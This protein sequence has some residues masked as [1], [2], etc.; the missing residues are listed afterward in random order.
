MIYCLTGELLMLDAVSMTAVIDCGG[1]GYKTTITTSTLSYLNSAPRDKVRIYTYM[2]VREDSV[3]LY[4]FATSEELS[5]FK[6]LITVSGVGPKAAIS[7]LSTLGPEALA[8]TIAAEDAK[9]IAK[10]PGVGAKTAARI[11]LELKDKLAKSMPE[12][13]SSSVQSTKA[14]SAG[15]GGSLSDARDALIVLGYSRSEIAQALS[16]ADAS[17]ATE[18][19]IRFALAKLMK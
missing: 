7:I 2:A 6:L 5:T 10:A 1:V 9:A 16:G 15:G 11:V 12:L 4:G 13:K 18:E 17:L 14:A 19:L 3:E 8:M